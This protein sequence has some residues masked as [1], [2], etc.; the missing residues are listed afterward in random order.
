M[1]L[2][3][4][5]LACLA[6]RGNFLSTLDKIT[7]IDQHAVE[8]RIG[9]DHPILVL[10]QNQRAKGFDLAA[11]KG[12][13]PGS[14]R[15]HIGPGNCRNIDPVIMYPARRWAEF[16]DYLTLNRPNEWPSRCRRNELLAL[17]VGTVVAACAGEV[18]WFLSRFA[19]Q[20]QGWQNQALPAGSAAGR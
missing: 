1:Q 8:M 6:D 12:N 4:V 14:R 10:D 18:L 13:G 9:G 11:D 19:G 15:Q 16:G 20:C 7:L 17:G 2:R 3:C 5:N